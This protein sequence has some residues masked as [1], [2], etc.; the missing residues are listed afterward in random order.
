MTQPEVHILMPAYNVE[1][2]LSRSMGSVLAQ[3]YSNVKLLFRDDASPDN[4]LKVAKEFAKTAGAGKVHVMSSVQ[5]HGI[6]Y[7]R[8]MLLEESKQL[9]PY[10]YTMWL[11]ADDCF[12][13][14][15]AVADVMAQ[16]QKTEADICLFNFSVSWEND[17]EA[18]KNNAKGLIRDKAKHEALLERIS[19]APNGVFSGIDQ[20]EVLEATSL[21]WVKAYAPRMKY[22]WP[23]MDPKLIF[24]DFPPMALL[25]K[26]NKVT[27]LPAERPVI[28]YMRRATSAT[29]DRKPEH[30]YVDVLEQIKCFE[31]QVVKPGALVQ[32]AVDA[33]K[34]NK[35]AQYETVLQSLI[36]QK[37]PGFD[38]SVH[39]RYIARA[40]ELKL[41]S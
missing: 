21:G 17:T 20:P 26:T 34:V 4:T 32:A 18:L 37:K 29:G 24:E 40:K 15:N 9:N 12:V 5:N 3:T 14:K 33:F 38:P 16:M 2:H 22:E 1:G 19:A 10:A 11:D 30:F 31:T 39:E 36:E 7:N 41:V 23:I 25:L 27:A 13:D 6:S 28:D 35:V 8:H